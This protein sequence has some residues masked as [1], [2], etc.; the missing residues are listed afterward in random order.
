MI[1]EGL[2]ITIM[3]GRILGFPIIFILLAGA[4]FSFTNDALVEDWLRNNTITINA[5][6]S[7]T[8]PIQENETW[9]V[10]VVDFRDDNNQAEEMISAAES[11][12]KPHAQEYF[13][14]LS[15]GTV[16]LE[17]DIHNV[18]F[19][20]ANPMTSYGAD[21]GAER[22]S[23][24]DGT[25]LPMMLAEEAIV[26]FS[27]S[28][29]WSKYDLDND[30]TVDRLMI[31]HTAVGQET[32]GDSNRI[33]SHFAMFQKPIDLPNGIKSPHYAMASIGSGSSGFGTA[34]HEMLHQMGAYDLYPSDGQQTSVWKGVGDWDIMASGNW[35]DDGKTPALPMSSTKE[36]IGLENYHTLT[37]DWQQYPDYCRSPTITIDLSNSFYHDYKIPLA[38][39]E[40]VWIEYRGGNIYD[41]QLPGTGLLVSYQDTTI[42][43]YEDNELNINNKRPYLKVIEADG[44]N[45][46]LNGANQGQS[47]DLFANGSSFGSQGVEIRNHDG[48]LVDW[49]AEVQISTQ[50]EIVFKKNSC[51]S[52]FSV[53]LPDHAITTLLNENITF[54]AESTTSCVIENNL[55]STDGRLVAISPSQIAANTPTNIEIM[56]NS[57]AQHN[58]KARMIG[59]LSCNS[60]VR[61][62]DIEILSLSIIP[63]DGLFNSKISVSNRDNIAIPIDSIGTGSH[64]FSYLIDGPLS[65]IADSQQTLRIAESGSFLV[66]DIEPNGLLSHNMIVNG[67]IVLLDSNDNKYVID[68]TLTAESAAGNSLNEYINPGQLIGLACLFAA[69]WVFLTM[70]DATQTEVKTIEEPNNITTTETV[71]VDAWGRVIDD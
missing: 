71:H 24:V 33:W 29:D 40:F 11:M 49:F 38:S 61:D 60:E 57:A 42:D 12:L 70:R 32:G 3:K 50:V 43:G 53:D 54:T 55:V 66:L 28:I 39:G 26:E 62:F 13:D 15:H 22:D 46:L 63:L 19:T 7:Q 17:I 64:T 9:L 37:F 41:Q 59:N 20:A 23:A 27:D 14:T 18:M 1:D 34:M 68:V 56:F 21:N 5:E 69:L 51:N 67:E 65:R 2:T 30:G 31:L 48:I 47:S 44:N 6:E 25:H 8:L 35:N 58:S 52:Q 36:T 16:S 4:A 10:L 45:G